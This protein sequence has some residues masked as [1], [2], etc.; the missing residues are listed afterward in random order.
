MTSVDTPD[1]P[2]L[3]NAPFPAFDRIE[4]SDVVPAIGSILRDA[5]ARLEQLETQIEPTW[6]GLL[7]PLAELDVLF[8]R[9]WGAVSHLFG[10]KNSDALRSAY[11]EVLGDVV[12]FGLRVS[13]SEPIYTALKSLKQSAA[14]E[15]LCEAQQRIVDAKLLTAE[16]AGV[17]L[18]DEQ[19]QR[20]N[21]AEQRLSQLSTDFSNHVLDATKA[22]EI[23]IEDRQQVDGF[24]PSLLQ[25]CSQSY[26]QEHRPS[27]AEDEDPRSTP[28]SGP[29]RITLDLPCYGPF[30]QHCRDRSLR[31]QVYRAF[32]TRA[33]DG[34]LNN[35]QII[36]EILKLRQE[37]AE[38]LGYETYAAA[39][40]AKKM[41]P[42]VD[43]VD[44]MF[45]S[46][47]TASWEAAV[48]DMRDIQTLAEEAGETEPLQH[49]DLPFWSERLR[50][51]RFD[52]TDEQIRPYFSLDRVLQGMFDLVRHL[53][54]VTVTPADGEAP[55]WHDDVRFFHVHD[56]NGNHL[57]SF[58]LDPFS[59]PENKRGGAWMND[60]L[61]RRADQTE[62]QRPVAH[63]VCNGTPPVG[64]KPSLMTFREVETLFHEFGH[65]LQ[66]LLTRVDYPDA[67]GINGVEWD[68]V[69]LPSQFMENWCYH[70]PTL[71]GMTAHYETGEPLP[72]ELFEKICAARTFRAGTQM[73][74]QLQFGMTDME[75]HHRFDLAGDEDPFAVQR[76]IS[77]DTSV[78]PALNEDRSLCSFQHIFAGGYAA[79]YYSYKWAEVLSAD[80]FSAFE[81]AGLA[82][83]QAVQ[84]T[85]L[86]FRDTVLALGGGRHPMQVFRDFRG[87]DPQPAALLRHNGLGQ[88]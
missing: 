18:A 66:H 23:V 46:L 27:A 12:A 50:E 88:P 7:R 1:N 36:G 44:Q 17:G 72:E 3:T 37:K 86:R 48:K 43:A 64:D 85:G 16:L 38:L 55:V 15:Q 54:A 84:E 4:P 30:L 62:L 8:E 80:A 87:R 22:F 59:R 83:P 21:A 75:L 29:W 63:L 82:D 57:S 5:Q 32:I 33:S 70:K 60:C 73:L 35:S 68:A 10:V 61:A 81:E 49:W 79:G 9:S 78:L 40:L 41:A 14:W 74:R 56:D 20:F 67:A 6:A 31:E 51:Q 45:H 25:L 42:D 65:G 39:S 77:Q 52:Y 76:R 47:R 58:Y 2:L 11:E 24:P 69:E 19:R 34:D 71:L 13:Q 28:E 26:N 53:F